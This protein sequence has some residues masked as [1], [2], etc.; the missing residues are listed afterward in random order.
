MV[1]PRFIKRSSKLYKK[2][3]E[4]QDRP[5]LTKDG[6]QFNVGL[7]M[8]RLPIFLGY[9]SDI[10]K[11]FKQRYE[12]IRRTEYYNVVRQELSENKANPMIEFERSSSDNMIT[13][14]KGTG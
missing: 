9:N 14:Q 2:F 12:L 4:N 5:M 8:H 6:Y 7:I 11:S 10:V 1:D 3:L 13:H